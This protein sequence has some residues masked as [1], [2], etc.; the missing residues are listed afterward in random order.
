MAEKEPVEVQAKVTPAVK[1]EDAPGIKSEATKAAPAAKKDTIEVGKGELETILAR[2]QQLEESNKDQTNRLQQYEKTAPQDQIA[3]IEA[4]RRSGK[5]VK[6][7]KI[8]YILDREADVKKA[9]VAWKMVKDEVWFEGSVLKEN[10]VVKVWFDDKS[11]KE[12]NQRDFVRFVEYMPYDVIS[13]TKDE[14]GNMFYT[15]RNKEGQELVI[16][17]QY[18]N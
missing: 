3:R 2:V 14:N 11:T 5:L 15:I 4:L 17:S 9:V 6:S 8:R 10:Q 7:V 18:V 16:G 1:K 13:E 12:M